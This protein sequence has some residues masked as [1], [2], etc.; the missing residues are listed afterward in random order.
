MEISASKSLVY[1]DKQ[2]LP[3]FDPAREL[4]KVA[5]TD[6]FLRCNVKFKPMVVMQYTIALIQALQQQS[7]IEHQDHEFFNFPLPEFAGP[8]DV[9]KD[10]ASA[11]TWETTTMTIAKVLH[12]LGL[13]EFHKKNT[14]LAP[15]A[16][17]AIRLQLVRADLPVQ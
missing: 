4:L 9:V 1:F 2:R 6:P 5:V 13:K 11:E 3:K 14:T 8:G 12:S 7:H 15:V 10:S 16:A 17:A